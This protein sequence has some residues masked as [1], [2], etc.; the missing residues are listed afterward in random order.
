VTTV[1]VRFAGGGGVIL[2][3]AIGATLVEA[4]RLPAGTT[5]K[6]PVAVTVWRTPE[7]VTVY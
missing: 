6:V 7:T 3:T 5:V 1:V 2:V 4:V